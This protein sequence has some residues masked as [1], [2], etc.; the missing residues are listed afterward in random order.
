MVRVHD[1]LWLATSAGGVRDL[2]PVV[3]TLVLVTHVIVAA[4]VIMV[5]VVAVTRG[6]YPWEMRREAVY[7]AGRCRAEGGDMRD[8]V[9]RLYAR[10]QAEQW[11]WPK[12]PDSFIKN[13]Q[14]SFDSRGS[15]LP[16]KHGRKSKLPDDV[17]MEIIDLVHAGYDKIIFI[18]G[19]PI[20]VRYYYKSF[21]QAC[22]TN[23]LI[24]LYM[25][26]YGFSNASSLRRHLHQHHPGAM[27]LHPGDIK[28]EHTPVQRAE[29]VEK[30]ILA[31]ANLQ[32]HPNL[33]SRLC[34]M[35]C[36]H[37]KAKP[38][39]QFAYYCS[40]NDSLGMNMVIEIPKHLLKNEIRIHLMAVV[41]PFFGPIYLEFVSGTQPDV[42]PLEYTAD[43]VK[44]YYV[45]A[46]SSQ[47]LPYLSAVICAPSLAAMYCGYGTSHTT[48]CSV[49]TLTS[50]CMQL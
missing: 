45:S 8:A 38:A 25:Q 4:V 22:S 17:A 46:A 39:A 29:R 32:A 16:V 35:D 48:S 34:V 21:S 41:N 20:L 12:N 7:L 40:P 47:L 50:A 14:H 24:K 19:Q 3:T 15:V 30:C 44:T 13:A 36:F 31:L 27:H 1:H 37:V 49:T 23:T 26:L 28:Q 33:L 6:H 42:K 18:S 5:A 10:A 11:P 43:Q 2:P 9:M